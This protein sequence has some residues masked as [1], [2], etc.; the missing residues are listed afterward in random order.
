[1]EFSMVC[2]DVNEILDSYLNKFKSEDLAYYPE[3]ITNQIA[4]SS[5]EVLYMKL[6]LAKFWASVSALTE[7]NC[8]KKDLY[9][10]FEDTNKEI[11]AK[12]IL[13]KIYQKEGEC[14]QNMIINSETIISKSM[15][16]LKLVVILEKLIFQDVL[17]VDHLT[18]PDRLHGRFPI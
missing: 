15:N 14:L 16:I 6:F 7:I 13:I 1:M 18:C 5:M 4:F 9:L 17:L 11:L 3:M 2:S 10:I 12:V 8:I